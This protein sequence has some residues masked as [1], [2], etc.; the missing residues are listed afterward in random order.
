MGATDT[1]PQKLRA[2]AREDDDDE[3]DGTHITGREEKQQQYTKVSFPH[4]MVFLE[5]FTNFLLPLTRS[6]CRK[7][8]RSEATRSVVCVRRQIFYLCSSVQHFIKN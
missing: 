5:N 8:S 4:S 2:L 6:E 1:E 7:S 3:E